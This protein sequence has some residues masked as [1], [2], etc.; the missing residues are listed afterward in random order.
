MGIGQ[1]R[2]IFE[3]LDDCQQ[4]IEVKGLAIRTVIDMPT[5]NS[6]TKEQLLKAMDW[7]WNQ[8]FELVKPDF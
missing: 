3:N 6:V 7:M 2:G 1:A 5:H 4:P 8:I